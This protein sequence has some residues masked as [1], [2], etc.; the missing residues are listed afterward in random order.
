[1]LQVGKHTKATMYRMNTRLKQT[2]LPNQ[3][4]SL[5]TTNS[6]NGTN[7]THD[8]SY[9]PTFVSRGPQTNL[10]TQPINSSSTQIRYY[11]KQQSQVRLFC[12]FSI[13]ILFI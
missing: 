5:A 8:N 3:L 1:M 7:L 10:E 6:Y 12:I 2:P 4:S 13:H 11:E 9:L